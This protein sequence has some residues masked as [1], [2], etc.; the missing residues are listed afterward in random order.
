MRRSHFEMLRPICPAC[1]RS[2]HSQALC[3]NVVETETDDDV[4]AGILGCAQCG[5]EYPV[6]DGLPVI[7]P[8]VRRYIQDNLF[9][10]M[11]RRDLTPAVESL[12]G[13]ASGPG[14]GLDSIRQH[15]SSYVWDH[16]GDQDPQETT[17]A[18]GDASPSG[19]ARALACGLEM[20][21]D[22]FPPGPVLDIGCGAGRSVVELADRTGRQILGIDISMPL[23]RVSRRAVVE[24]NV[25]YA[26]RRVGVAY[27]RRRFGIDAPH[28]ERMDVWICDVLALPF[29]PETFALAVGL[30]VLDCLTDPRLG[31]NEIG[32]VVRVG[33]Q[34]LLAVPFDWVA[35][36][37]PL[38][39]WIGGHSQRGPHAGSGEALLD[40][41]LSDGPLAAGALRRE[42]PTREVP[43]HVRLHERSCMHYSTH[44]VAARREVQVGSTT[45]APE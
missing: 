22:D 16:W 8:D 12:L 33:G 38:E 18:A 36:V 24:G 17:P 44:L 11:A 20:V 43:W 32:R 41:M 26:R 35:Q 10:I 25:D 23:A 2:G 4:I 6:I 28:C 19:V 3:I 45:P 30:N 42:K 31:L 5:R 14:S 1:N 27:D 13:D 34:A 15:V 40:L 7:V 9:Y 29:A 37:T 39:G 21:A